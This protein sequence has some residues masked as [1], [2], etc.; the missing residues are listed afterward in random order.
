MVLQIPFRRECFITIPAPPV[1]VVHVVIKFVGIVEVLIAALAISMT[2]RVGVVPNEA[3]VRREISVASVAVVVRRRV[4]E[5]LHKSGIVVEITITG[6]TNMPTVIVD[7][8]NHWYRRSGDAYF[9]DWR[10]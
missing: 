3:R 7:M 2:W 10:D 9:G 8:P 5:V 4:I 1:T 6:L